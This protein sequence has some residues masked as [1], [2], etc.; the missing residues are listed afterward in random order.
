MLRPELGRGRRL[1]LPLQAPR[2]H[3]GLMHTP[4]NAHLQ[5]CPGPLKKP[6][7]G[8]RQ[9]ELASIVV[10]GVLVSLESPPPSAEGFS[11]WR[12]P[13]FLSPRR[14]LST[15]QA[16]GSVEQVRVPTTSMWFLHGDTS[17]PTL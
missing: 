17:I 2:G 15:A 4:L 13:P 7:L 6:A 14:S 16:L 3:L 5:L 10:G 9:Q 1:G 8:V 12:E 11:Q